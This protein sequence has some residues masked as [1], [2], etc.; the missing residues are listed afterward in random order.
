MNDEI[1]KALQEAVFEAIRS[2]GIENFKKTS[3]FMSNNRAV[4]E[5]EMKKAA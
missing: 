4:A 3:F 2:V 5:T 1:K